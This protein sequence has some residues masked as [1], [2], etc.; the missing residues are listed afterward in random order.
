MEVGNPDISPPRKRVLSVLPVIRAAVLR[1]KRD[2]APIGAWLNALDAR[3]PKNV[4]VV[5]M[6]NKLARI[7]WAVLSSGNDYRPRV[8]AI[9]A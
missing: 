8:N 3:V 1:I 7:A 5:A 2:R 4:V 6:A 9:V